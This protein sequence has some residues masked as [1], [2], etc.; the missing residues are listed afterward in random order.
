MKTALTKN[1]NYALAIVYAL[2]QLTQ[3]MYDGQ[4]SIK[5]I[6]EFQKEFLIENGIHVPDSFCVNNDSFTLFCL[7]RIQRTNNPKDY[8]SKPKLYDMYIEYCE[9]LG[10]S[11]RYS[12]RQFHEQ[13]GRLGFELV[14]IHGYE[15]YKRIK[16][17]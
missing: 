14:K 1:G 8:L 5:D 4:V 16:T 2:K 12:R 15:T 17:V 10:Y 9:E 7:E 13:F 3:T 6:A 11:I